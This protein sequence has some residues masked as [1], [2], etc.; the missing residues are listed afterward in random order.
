MTKKYIISPEYSQKSTYEQTDFLQ[1]LLNKCRLN[2]GGKIIFKSGTY[3]FG[4]VR[5]F[6]NTE[7]YFEKNC[8]INSSPTL[9]YYTDFGQH[10]NIRYLK[11]PYFV[12]KWHLPK[13]Y[14][15]ALFCVY[16]AENIKIAAEDNVIFNG[17][18]LKDPAEE[19]G[20]RGP[21]MFVFSR[22]KHLSLSGYRVINSPNWSHAI[23]SC[24]DVKISNIT[25]DA[26]HDGFNLHH[27]KNILIEDCDLHTGDDCL[28]GYDIQNLHVKDCKF[29]SACNCLRIGGENILVETCSF[30]GPG[31]YPHLST[32]TKYSHDF[33]RYYALKSKYEE[34]VEGKNIRF[35][36]IRIANCRSLLRYDFLGED[37]MQSGAPLLDVSFEDCHISKLAETSQINSG[38]FPC[39]IKIKNCLIS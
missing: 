14:F 13:N 32:G 25:I 30:V 11:D 19:E 23:D 15:H 12:K 4:S 7:L 18:D 8:V 28:A 39:D 9:T 33:F 20:F 31:K 21:M 1:I 27:S 16:D 29:N 2:N 17:H 38:E 36:K 34:E 6:S 5:I 3:T 37:R 26:G 10:T 22:I 35:K 24:D